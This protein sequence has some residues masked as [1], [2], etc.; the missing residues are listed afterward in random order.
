MTDPEELFLNYVDKGE[1]TPFVCLH[2]WSLDL[3]FDQALYEPIFDQ[4]DS[5]RRIYLD[6]PGHGKTPGPDWIKNSF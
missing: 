3:E 1:G 6:M 2:G 5:F 4:R